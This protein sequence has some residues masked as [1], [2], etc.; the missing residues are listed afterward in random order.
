MRLTQ[1]QILQAVCEYCIRHKLAA[2]GSVLDVRLRIVDDK[3]VPIPFVL[4]EDNATRPVIIADVTDFG[5][6]YEA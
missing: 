1:D 3:G 6:P 4:V 5:I 2:N